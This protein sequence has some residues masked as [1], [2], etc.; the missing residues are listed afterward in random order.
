MENHD[1]NAKVSEILA[2]FEMY[3]GKYKREQIDAAISLKEEITPHLIEILENVL[4]DPEK[5]AANDDLYDR[6]QARTENNLE[7]SAQESGTCVRWRDSRWCRPALDGLA[8][9]HALFLLA[10][11]RSGCKSPG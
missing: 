5:Y 4:S 8:A 1:A 2:S 9:R 3:D 10:Q 6:E 7:N 11:P